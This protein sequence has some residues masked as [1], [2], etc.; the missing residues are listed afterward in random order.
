MYFVFAQKKFYKKYIVDF[1]WAL[2][3]SY[4]LTNQSRKNNNNK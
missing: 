1:L 2:L 4:V 3:P